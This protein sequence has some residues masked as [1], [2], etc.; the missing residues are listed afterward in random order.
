M[1]TLRRITTVPN[2][3]LRI[4]VDEPAPD[5]PDAGF[6]AGGSFLFEP[7]GQDG[8]TAGVSD[9]T[10]AVIMGDTSLAAHFDCSPPWVNPNAAPAAESDA[11][12]KPKRT[13]KAEPDADGGQ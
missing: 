12:L 5:S 1:Y 6:T 4:L 11:A 10:A 7:A 8:D 9:H 2:S 13:R 3:P